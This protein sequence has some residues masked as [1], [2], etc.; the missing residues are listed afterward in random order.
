[1]ILCF[2]SNLSASKRECAHQA[3]ACEALQEQVKSEGTRSMKMKETN[4]TLTQK[5]KELNER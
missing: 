2:Q 4:K 1:M 3:S 5:V